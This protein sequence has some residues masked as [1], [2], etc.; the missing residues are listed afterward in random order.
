MS[1]P[2]KDY[3]VGYG[4]PPKATQWKK[5][6]SGNPQRRYRAATLSALEKLDKRLLRPID[7]V[8]NDV[9]KKVTVLAAIILQ[10]WQKELAGD[11]RALSVRLKYEEIVR[12]AA[13]KG[14]H[15]ELVDSDYTRAL[16]EGR[17]PEGDGN[18]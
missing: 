7:I 15:V 2:P 13:E 12:E 6:Q 1:P 4:R 11:K 14:V 9:P 3:E 8:E 5:G 16:A 17:L 18:E 10:L